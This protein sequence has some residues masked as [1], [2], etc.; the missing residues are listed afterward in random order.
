M[1]IKYILKLC[2]F[3]VITLSSSAMG[4]SPIFQKTS[5]YALFLL[6]P[7]PKLAYREGLFIRLLQANEFQIIVYK[8]HI[9]TPDEVEKFYENIR[10]KPFYDEVSRYIMS[11][12]TSAF[13]AKHPED[14]I[15]AARTL[16]GPTDPR[17]ALPGTLRHLFFDPEAKDPKTENGIHAS[18]TPEDYEREKHLIF[19]LILPQN[20]K[21]ISDEEKR[22]IP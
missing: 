22:D 1:D 18:S 19:R 11:G 12:S 14:A 3:L 5:S 4:S 13:L 7:H 17:Q 8:N 9:F 21:H 2:L 20:R 16:L 6:K 10:Y 15:T